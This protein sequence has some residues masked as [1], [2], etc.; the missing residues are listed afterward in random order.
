[1]NYTVSL[2]THTARCHHAG[3]TEREYIEQAIADG[4]DVIGFADHAPYEFPGGYVSNFR[5]RDSETYGYFATL[6]DLRDEYRGKIDI[7]IGFEAEYYPDLFEGFIKGLEAYPI[8]YLILG[9]HYLDNETSRR[10]S[11][12]TTEDEAYLADYVDQVSAG[13]RTGV[14]SYVAHPDLVNFVGSPEIYE[15]QYSRLIECA[16][17]EGVPLEVNL[18]GIRAG[19]HYPNERFI[20]LCGKLGAPMCIG[21]DAHAPRDAADLESAKK[22][23]E[24]IKKYGVKYVESPT[25]RPVKL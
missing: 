13:I 19:R 11:G 4:L 25:L 1:M 15:K 17:D 16:R 18:L 8:D 10:Y 21:A 14:Y 6:L 5:M 24:L 22:A 2:H 7:K 20:S 12:A 3:G 23:L 9:Q